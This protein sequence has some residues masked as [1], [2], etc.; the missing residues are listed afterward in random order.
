[1]RLQKTHTVSKVPDY[2][3]MFK[4]TAASKQAS[5]KMHLAS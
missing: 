2:G 3:D 4:K 1:M 5:N